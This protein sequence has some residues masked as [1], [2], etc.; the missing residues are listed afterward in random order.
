MLDKR[1]HVYRTPSESG[2]SSHGQMKHV[3]NPIS[4]VA[5]HAYAMPEIDRSHDRDPVVMYF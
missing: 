4:P 2:Y 3:R 5:A 1:T